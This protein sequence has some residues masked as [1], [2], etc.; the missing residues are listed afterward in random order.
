VLAK[1]TKEAYL[2]DN[3]V[4]RLL[5]SIDIIILEEINILISK[6]LAYISSYSVKLKV[7][8]Y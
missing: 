8:V 5:I 7:K 6:K 1:V 4:I 2:I 3:L